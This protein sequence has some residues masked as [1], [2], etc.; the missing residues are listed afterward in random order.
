MGMNVLV[1][2]NASYPKKE[3][4]TDQITPDSESICRP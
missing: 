4:I 2:H 3:E 1:E